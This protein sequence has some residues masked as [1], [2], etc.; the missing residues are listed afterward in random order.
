[1]PDAAKEESQ[2]GIAAFTKYY[3]ELVDYTVL[4]YDTRPIKAVTEQTCFLCAKQLID[5]ADS[6]VGQPGWQVGG[7]TTL[8]VNFTKLVD[9]SAFSGFTF[10]RTKTTIYISEGEVQGEVPATKKPVA[11]TL[12]LVYTPSKIWKVAD[13]EFIDVGK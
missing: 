1:M 13:I 2:E 6:N 7:K 3:F 8:R 11:G 12:H 10:H 5:P 4:T 9:G